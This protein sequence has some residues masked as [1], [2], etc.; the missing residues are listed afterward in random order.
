MPLSRQ[1]LET[2][3]EI[4]Q[5][6][7]LE[8]QR[9][10]YKSTARRYRTAASQVNFIRALLALLTGVASAMA[11]LF[12]SANPTCAATDAPPEC[13]GLITFTS[14]LAILSIILPALAALFGTLA[15]LYQWDRLV[16]IYD[17]AI[18]NIEVA[19]AQSPDA[20]ID[21]EVKYR[22]AYM[23]YTEGTLL[24]MNDESSQWGQ[25]IRTPAQVEAYLVK[26]QL[27][28]Q[29]VSAQYQ[30]DTSS[31]TATADDSKPDEG[32]G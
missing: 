8:D 20:E 19:D 16:K 11:T 17:E 27:R 21:D 14:I 9:S 26:A 5:Q 22:A 32:V 24:V 4:F 29:Q 30:G 1:D 12:I 23:T 10:Y 6:F 15:D 7:A 31:S 3:Y 18:L 25:A 13:G 2:R 28:A